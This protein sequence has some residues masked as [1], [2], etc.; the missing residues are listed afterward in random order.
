MN[1]DPNYIDRQY[2][3]KNNRELCGQLTW[4]PKDKH[5]KKNKK[6]KDP[7]K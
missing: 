7:K 4:L 2:R 3:L 5:R 6:P 1:N